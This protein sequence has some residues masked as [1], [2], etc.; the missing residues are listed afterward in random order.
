M[1]TEN[2]HE[3]AASKPKAYDEFASLMRGVIDFGLTKA[4]LPS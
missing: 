3:A 4:K 2:G 1:C